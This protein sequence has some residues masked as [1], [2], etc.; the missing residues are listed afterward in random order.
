MK[1]HLHKK[2]LKISLGFALIGLVAGGAAALYQ[3]SMFPEAIRQQITD[4]LGSLEALIPIAASQGAL[5]TFLAAFFGQKL[6]RKTGLDLGFRWDR[7]AFILALF[8]GAGAA[9]VI[10]G[11]DRFVFSAYL[12]EVLTDYQFSPI[13]LITGLL[14]GG[15]IEE[16][17]L[18]LFTQL[19]L[20]GRNP[21]VCFSLCRRTPAFHRSVHRLV[22][23][24][25]CPGPSAEQ[26]RRHRFWL[27]LL[28]E[29]AGLR[30]DRP[31]RRPLFHAAALHAP[32][33]L[34]VPYCLLVEI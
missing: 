11:S 25:H 12:P 1:N 6:A 24:H 31:R 26:H 29:G 19:D 14:Y 7:K 16:V 23:T 3:L 22:R 34:S 10:T 20:L 18:R 21:S 5:L 27:P 13:Y 17:L 4:Q 2:D 28:E 8:I 15:I 33:L 9:L 32:L 30:H